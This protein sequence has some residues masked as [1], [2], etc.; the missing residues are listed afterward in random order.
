MD[1]NEGYDPDAESSPEPTFPG[2]SS[3][4]KLTLELLMNK[5]KFQKYVEKTDPRKYAEIQDHRSNII[6]H[7]NSILSMAQDLLN[8][9]DMQINTEINDSFDAFVKSAIRHIQ[10]K[11]MQYKNLPSSK[12]PFTNQDDA[13]EDDVLFGN[14]DNEDIPSSS[15]WGKDRVVK[16][17]FNNIL[18]YG[19]NNFPRKPDL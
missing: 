17:K 9:P 3:I 14:M 11:E 5:S 19:M 7:R 8:D 1:P 10:Y 15:F 2:N 18:N 16:S 13:D 4:D 12:S 6:K